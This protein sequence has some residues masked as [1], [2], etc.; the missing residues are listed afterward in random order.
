VATVAG[1][2]DAAGYLAGIV[3]GYFFGRILDFGGYSLGFH[4]LGL[5]TI[6]AALLS[7]GLYRSQ[8]GPAVETFA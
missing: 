1:L 4:V 3:S 6:V 5:L 7:L 2:V 8:P